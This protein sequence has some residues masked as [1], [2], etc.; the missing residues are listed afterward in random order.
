[1]LL[2]KCPL[3]LGAWLTAVTGAGVSTAAAATLR[4]GLVVAS[5]AA[6]LL[7]AAAILQRLVCRSEEARID[8]A[9][10]VPQRAQTVTSVDRFAPVVHN[11]NK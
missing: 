4:D 11:P 6:I 9:A 5:I 10:I 2:P 7:V 8:P 1:M 3:C